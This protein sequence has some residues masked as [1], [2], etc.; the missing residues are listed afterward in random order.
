MNLG[1][2]RSAMFSQ[3]D[4]A[5]KQ[6]EDAKTRANEFINRAYFQLVQEAPFLFFE[7]RVGFATIEDDTPDTTAIRELNPASAADTVSVG[8]AGADAW[9]LK[10]DLPTTTGGLTAWDTTGR[11]NGRMI[12]ITDPHGVEHRR[13][14]REIWTDTHV[15]Y[16]SLF[17]PW[18]NLTDTLMD[19]RI[20]SEDYYLPDNVIEVNSIRLFRQNQ[21]FPLDIIGQ[22]E[23]EY[24]SLADSPQSTVGG[25]PRC[26]FRRYHRQ[27]ESPTSAPVASYGDNNT[28]LGPEPAG[29]FEY[30]FTYTWGYRDEDFRDFGPSQPYNA[31][32][33]EPSRREPLWESSPSPIV[34]V[35]TSNKLEDPIVFGGKAIVITT[36]DIHYMQGFGRNGD[37]RY[38]RAGWRKRIYRRRITVD[39]V[40]YNTLTHTLTGAVDQETPDAFVLIADIDG[41]QT[42]FIDNGQIL[43]D[44]NRRL[45]EVHGYQ[46][47]RLYPRP[48]ERYQV[49]VRCLL[50]PEE[51]KDDQD[52]PEI[53]TDGIDVLLYRA[54][55]FL[56]ESQGNI[57]LADRAI[58]R[59]REALFTL[60]KRYGD[61]RYPGETLMK[62][63]A[64]SGRIIDTRRA[65][66]RW[67]N[68]PSS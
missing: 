65:Y 49:D 19:W 48:N 61:L 16:I 36:P 3:A 23:A 31:A 42:A 24:L 9:V 51:L 8:G 35:T 53:H 66:R 44:Y 1:E 54:L 52:A 38:R 18:N 57:E 56:Y 47:V 15:Q 67:Y 46:S 40:N 58:G 2:I 5:P 50:R 45:R 37:R 6:S 62:R 7:K 12:L 33:T 64:R 17:Q 10:R 32:Q 27:I 25:L 41:H 63:P 39:P 43:P 14:I 21:N 30:C 20:Y 59:F 60:T 4:W 34:S 26:A 11:W 13:M 28:W 29:Q 55:S 22:M 68:L